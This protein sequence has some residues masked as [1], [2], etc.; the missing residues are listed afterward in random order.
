MLSLVRAISSSP[1]AAPCASAR[2]ALLG[3]PFPISVLQ[4]ISV[5]LFDFFASIKALSILSKL[6]PSMSSITVHP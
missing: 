2:P 5:G 1:N 6:C 4:H 3:E